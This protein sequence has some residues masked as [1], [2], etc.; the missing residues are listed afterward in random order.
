MNNSKFKRNGKL[1]IIVGW[2]KYKNWRKKAKLPLPHVMRMYYVSEHK[3]LV[4]N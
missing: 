2:I 4:Y 1:S 3:I